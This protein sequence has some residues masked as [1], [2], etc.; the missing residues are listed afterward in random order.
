M[1]SSFTVTGYLLLLFSTD[2]L[3]TVMANLKDLNVVLQTYP[4]LPQE[5]GLFVGPFVVGLIAM[6]LSCMCSCCCCCC[7]AACP[8]CKCCKK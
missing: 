6:M 4:N 7:P 1:K 2:L 3:K 5:Y 8:P